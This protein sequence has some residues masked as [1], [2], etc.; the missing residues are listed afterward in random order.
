M[1]FAVPL[2]LAMRERTLGT[3]PEIEGRPG[4]LDG[5]GLGLVS[6]FALILLA[7]GMRAAGL[8]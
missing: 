8:I 2:F 6:A 1:A 3:S 5:I 7:L 4:T